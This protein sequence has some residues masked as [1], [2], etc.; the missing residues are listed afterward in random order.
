MVVFKPLT[1]YVRPLGSLVTVHVKIEH[2]QHL[3]QIVLGLRWEP[4][5]ATVPE[6]Q[7]QTKHCIDTVR[8]DATTAVAMSPLG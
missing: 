4:S 5:C 3:D 8:V 6:D 7:F 2:S 1:L